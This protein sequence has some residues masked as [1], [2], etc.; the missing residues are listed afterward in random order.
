M[1]ARRRTR[2]QRDKRGGR[3]RKGKRKGRWCEKR[4]KKK[5]KE[6]EKSYACKGQTETRLPLS[7]ELSNGEA[8]LFRHCA[9]VLADRVWLESRVAQV[10]QTH[11]PT[12]ETQVWT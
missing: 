7:S 12:W 9:R 1:V 10:D 4:K 5:E 3:K 11:G 2:S 8:T 6:K